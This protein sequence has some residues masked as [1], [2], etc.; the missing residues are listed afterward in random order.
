MDQ[1]S[2]DFGRPAAGDSVTGTASAAET[3]GT[4]MEEILV[5]RLLAPEPG[6][7]TQPRLFHRGVGGA[8]WD[9]AERGYYVRPDARLRF[10]SWFNAFPAS[11]YDLEPDDRVV[12]RLRGRGAGL[13]RIG[14]TRLGRDD[15]MLVSRS[16]DL[17]AGETLEVE[18]PRLIDPGLVHF[19][20]V[21]RRAVILREAD[22]LVRAPASRFRDVHVAAVITTFRR[23]AE[24]QASC[25][26]LDAY[27]KAN[28]DVAE[29]FS[30][31]VVD[32]GGDTDTVPFEGGRV[33]KNRNLGGAGGFTRGLLEAKDGGRATHVLF[34]DDD[35]EF[36]AENLRRT[37]AA[38]RLARD[39]RAAI[40][41][42]MI[43]ARDRWKIWENTALFDKLCVPL[44]KDV[45]LRRF[46][47]VIGM[48][49]PLGHLQNRYAGWWYFCFPLEKVE[50][51]P[52]PFFVRG[53]DV[54]FSLAND[55]DIRTLTGVASHQ[56]DFVSKR[57]PLTAY[58]DSRYHVMQMLLHKSLPDDEKTLRDQLWF[59]FRQWNE[60]Y[61]YG[62]AAAVVQAI[63]DVT[64]GSE[65]WD[66]DPEMSAKRAQIKALAPEESQIR[67]QRWRRSRVTPVSEKKHTSGIWKF[68]RKITHQ[69]HRAP[70]FMFHTKSAIFP[71]EGRFR[72]NQVFLRREALVVDPKSGVGYRL[73]R[74]PKRYYENNAK[75][76][77]AFAALLAR[78]PALR[79][80]FGREDLPLISEDAWRRRLGMSTD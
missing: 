48:T 75:F 57:S 19:R 63:E 53:D 5:Q 49:R 17:R 58:L 38:L 77:A 21:A 54:F 56:D 45:N 43:P 62:S 74:D 61:H 66:E 13:L 33:I 47:Q 12:L 4:R 70:A 35:A 51:L 42:A 37:I 60:S 71:L 30:L 3:G 79:E 34:M 68:I 7:N 23:D 55:F 24:V 29:R 14:M 46:E 59:L 18:L 26:R 39:P 32:N 40:A 31:T 20:I 8:G 10:D 80:E 36:F 22:W 2:S 15:E 25:A 9:S 16:F 41:G 65:F 1:T 44:Q 67:P 73:R 50:K 76:E 6:I 69:G 52:F 28:P 11:G 64:R 72:P 27:M 78:L